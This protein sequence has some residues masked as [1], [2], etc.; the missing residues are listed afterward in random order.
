ML[1]VALLIGVILPST[2][3]AQQEPMRL[4]DEPATFTDVADALDD[5]DPFDLN[6]SVGYSRRVERSTITRESSGTTVDIAGYERELQRLDF[7][8]EIGLF[9]DVSL[10]ARMPF[11][12]SDDRR[13]TPPDGRART[14]VEQDLCH[15]DP[16]AG[17]AEDCSVPETLNDSSFLFRV[18]TA[19]TTRSGIEYIAAGLNFG[20]MNQSRDPHLAT[21]V[22]S[23][24]GRFGVGDPLAL[25]SRRVREEYVVRERRVRG[26]TRKQL[27]SVLNH[28]PLAAFD[29]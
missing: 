29:I 12:L 6:L 14:D 3:A 18:P 8:L 13:L 26:S 2:T 25:A 15:V 20:L 22:L 11:V 27:G 9:R 28:E 17:T 24:E 21:W 5:D 16:L 19:S 4:M 23:V 1:F 10:Y 7:G